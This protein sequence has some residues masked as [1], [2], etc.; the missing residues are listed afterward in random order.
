MREIFY[1]RKDDQGKQYCK[2]EVRAEIS[3]K[4]GCHFDNL[5]EE[6]LAEEIVT[7]EVLRW[8]KVF[9]VAET[10]RGRW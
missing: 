8:N 10:K 9:C 5:D 7:S 6:I 3:M 1:L 2:G 4:E